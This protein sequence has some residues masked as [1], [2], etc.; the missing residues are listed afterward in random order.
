[1]KMAAGILA[2]LPGNPFVY[3]GEEIGMIG[4]GDDPNKRIGML[5][6][7][8]GPST[9]NPPGTTEA[10]YVLPSVEEQMKDEASLLNYYKDVMWLRHK[11][12]EIARGTS[13]ILPCSNTDLCLIRRTWGETSIVIAVNPSLR[14]H[15]VTVEGTLADSLNAKGLEITLQEGVLTL[16]SYSIAI[17]K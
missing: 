13:E 11:H 9:H 17:L 3:Y 5:W 4:T 12:P 6:T 16:P 10:G 1:M 2:M 14:D 7:A 8:D 15:T